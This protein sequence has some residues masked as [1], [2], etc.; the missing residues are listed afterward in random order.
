[1]I[2][3]K[4]YWNKKK[5]LITGHTGFKGA[6]LSLIL[7]NLG[8]N[9]IGVSNKYKISNP[10][11]FKELKLKNKINHNIFDIRNKRK[12]NDLIKQSKPDIIF[13]FAA[14]SIVKENFLNPME[15]YTTNFNGTL[16]L[17]ESLRK[18]KKS[19]NIIISTTDKVYVNENSK[20]KY[21]HE[22]D[23]LGSIDTY[24]LSKV[25]V[26]QV[27]KSYCLKYFVDNKIKVS[28]VRAGNVIGGGDWAEDRLIPDLVRT[29]LK[30]KKIMIR[31]LD[32]V[33]PWQHV[34]EA[35]TAYIL[36]AQ[37]MDKSKKKYDYYNIGPFNKKIYSVKNVIDTINKKLDINIKYK[38]I[39]IK[40]YKEDYILLL[41]SKKAIKNLKLKSKFKFEK[42]ILKTIKW[43]IDFYNNKN[44]IDICN[45]DLKEYG[46]L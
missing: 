38:K 28:M 24:A 17:L 16:N 42:T 23:A 34:I 35:L 3:N 40:K 19:I 11:L 20:I 36:L 8:A 13:H 22:D 14:V 21:F 31:N 44:A 5:V 25:M 18:S 26:E 2:F 43:Y 41:N 30:N 29:A 32:S 45:S 33:R 9:V 12:L 27:T 10:S 7:I 1:M 4:S 6:W 39:K 46:I 37:K 15:G